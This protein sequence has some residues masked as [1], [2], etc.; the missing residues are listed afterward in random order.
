MMMRVGMAST[1]LR[2]KTQSSAARTIRATITPSFQIANAETVATGT[3]EILA[4]S[5]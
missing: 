4:L 5:D 1:E 3:D 2:L